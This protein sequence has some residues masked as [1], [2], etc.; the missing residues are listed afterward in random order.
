FCSIL[1]EE[2]QRLPVKYRSPLVLCYLEGR[3]Q[4]EAAAQ[5]GCSEATLNRRLAEGRERLRGRLD[6]RGI[7]LAG[8]LLAVGLTREAS[9]AVPAALA[10]SAARA[11]RAAG[12]VSARVLGLAE[13]AT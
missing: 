5:L 13:A 1:D 10:A 9:A 4:A 2:L 12:G 3:A 7:T 6:R 8:G 11:A